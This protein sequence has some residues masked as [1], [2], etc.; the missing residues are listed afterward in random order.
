MV[1]WSDS[2]R[3]GDKYLSI[4]KCAAKRMMD[5]CSRPGH[6][7]TQNHHNHPAE[8]GEN[9]CASFDLQNCY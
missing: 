2:G 7:N 5:F 1:D 6:T 9:H 8:D 4:I 3:D